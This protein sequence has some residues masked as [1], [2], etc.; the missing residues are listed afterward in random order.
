MV[1]PQ[2]TKT[3]KTKTAESVILVEVGDN[4]QRILLEIIKADSTHWRA[5]FTVAEVFNALS[6]FAGKIQEIQKRNN[7]K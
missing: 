5:S 1:F 7:N 3:A 6:H 4:L 2:K